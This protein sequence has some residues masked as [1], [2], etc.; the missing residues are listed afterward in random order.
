MKILIVSQYF[1]PEIFKINDIA[2]ALT[3]RGHQVSVLTGKPNYPG[4]KFYK[5]YSY[6]NSSF[7]VWNN[8]KIYRSF[9]TPRG[10]GKGFFLF[11]NYM[12]FALFS[13][14]RLVFIIVKF[15]SI[16]SLILIFNSLKLFITRMISSS[17]LIV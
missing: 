7:E 10:N 5:N 12:S 8:I 15:L 1:W 2:Q 11:L 6:C 13:S 16:F 3:E 9:I 17:L 4:G 14:F